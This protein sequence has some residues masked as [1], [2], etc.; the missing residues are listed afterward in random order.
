MDRYDYGLWTSVVFNILFF[1]AFV[2]SFLKPRKKAE[3][4]SMGVVTGFIVALF[5]EMY[6][7]PLT[8]YLLVSLFG[9]RFVAAT[10]FGHLQGH[11]LGTIFNLSDPVILFICQLGNILMFTG[12]IIMGIGWWQIHRSQGRM[13][14]NGLYRLIRHPQYTG[15]FLLTLGMLVQWPTLITMLMWP[16]LMITYYRLAKK[17]EAEMEEQFGQH[18]LLYRQVTPAVVPRLTLREQTNLEE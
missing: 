1:G 8:I 2:L 18:Y 3:W 6:G 12:I 5:A 17:E 10:P 7:F 15:L 13:V 11:L 9:G 4:R 16:I 14:T